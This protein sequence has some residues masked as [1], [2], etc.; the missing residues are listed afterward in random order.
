MICSTKIR[1]EA[2]TKSYDLI[3]K[4]ISLSF[5][6]KGKL[7]MVKKIFNE[8][9]LQYIPI[10]E[11]VYSFRTDGKSRSGHY[12]FN[13]M[14]GSESID[15]TYASMYEYKLGELGTI[16]QVHKIAHNAQILKTYS[17]HKK[18][19]PRLLE[20]FALQV[21]F[22][23]RDAI[24]VQLSY[25][26]SD[27]SRAAT[28]KAYADDSMKLIE[29]P[30]YDKNVD[31]WRHN[32]EELKGFFTY[33]CVHGGALR[34]TSFVKD[35]PVPKDLY[36]GWSNSNPIGCTFSENNKVDIMISRQVTHN[37]KFIY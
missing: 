26:L 25:K 8:D 22:F 5:N 16:F 19:C 13:P 29:R 6:D 9:E 31:I 10:E 35:D 11:G 21:E 23:S 7:I 15:F 36:F 32:D 3:G 30:I 14:S 17:V 18:G 20:Q 12:I 1:R 33:P 34:K 37:G 24:E 28:Y 27:L 2:I 4:N